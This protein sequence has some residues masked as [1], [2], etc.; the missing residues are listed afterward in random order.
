M[1][2]YEKIL[3]DAQE[4][5][6]ILGLILVGSR[7]KG[8]DNEYSDYDL[9]MIAKPEAVE[10]LEK[11]YDGAKDIDLTIYSLTRGIDITTRTCRYSYRKQ[12]SLQNSLLKKV[13]SLLTNK[14]K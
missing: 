2:D 12:M 3:K 1:T 4:N 10:P 5:P 9:V 11:T 7:G 6:D 13:T 14:N 8:F